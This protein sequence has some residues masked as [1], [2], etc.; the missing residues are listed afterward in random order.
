MNHRAQKSPGRAK[1]TRTGQTRSRASAAT[2]YAVWES[3]AGEDGKETQN[4][5]AG[6]RNLYSCMAG[7]QVPTA[8]TKKRRRLRM[9]ECLGR[10]CGGHDH[11]GGGGS[12]LGPKPKMAPASRRS[13]AQTLALHFIDTVGKGVFLG[14]ERRG[15]VL[16]IVSNEVL[17]RGESN[18]G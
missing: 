8:T 11:R 10:P 7:E 17:H 14:K 13:P 4:W 3:R 15:R 1:N 5:S 6:R 12:H 2:A 9:R 16:Y 18:P